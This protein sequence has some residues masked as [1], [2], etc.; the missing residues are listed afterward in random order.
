MAFYPPTAISTIAIAKE[1]ALSFKPILLID[2]A[3]SDGSTPAHFATDTLTYSSVSYTGCVTKSTLDRV[4][5]MNSTGLDNFP[6]AR[7][8]LADPSATLFRLYELNSTG[9]GFKGAI[10]TMTLVMMDKITGNFTSD[11]KIKFIGR[12]E[13]AQSTD[14]GISFL[15]KSKLDLARVNIPNVP[16]S[17]LCPY[18]F[19]G[20]AAEQATVN[21]VTSPFYYCGFPGGGGFTDCNYDVI[22]C[23]DRGMLS[24]G[25][26]GGV[27]YEPPSTWYN[28]HVY[29][30]G[31]KGQGWNTDNQAKYQSYVPMVYGAGFVKGVVANVLGNGDSV[32]FEVICAAGDHSAS[33]ISMVLV[34][35]VAVPHNDQDPLSPGNGN[36]PDD[37]FFWQYINT[38]IRNSS[39]NPIVPWN[40]QGDPY[41]SMLVIAVVV[42]S[43]VHGSSNS[44]PDVLVVCGAK[45]VRTY[46]AGLSPVDGPDAGRPIWTIMDIMCKSG[47]FSYSDFDLQSAV[48]A[49]AVCDV[50]VPFIGLDGAY[51]TVSVNNGSTA[52]TSA[53]GGLF[54][55]VHIYA[56]QTIQMGGVN[57][58]VASITDTSHL[59]LASPYT[60]STS[61][62]A[63]LLRSHGRYRL[64]LVIT[65]RTS[66]AELL[67]S[68]RLGC[69][70]NIAV[71]NSTNKLQFY[72]DQALGDQQPS[73]IAGSN[74]N[75]SYAS[76]LATG[77]NGEADGRVG[78]GHVAYNF[79]DSNILLDGQEPNYSS[80]LKISQ[81][82]S[83]H[84]PN[85][86]IVPFQN[87]E[88]SFVSDTSTRVDAEDYNRMQQPVEG[89]VR[90]EGIPNYDQIFRRS[91]N[92]MAR[93]FRGNPR[94]SPTYGDTGGTIQCELK[95]FGPRVAHLRVGNIVS[96]TS[97][98][99]GL[100]KQL[101]RV[102]SIATDDNFG[103][104]TVTM[105]WHDDRWYLDGYANGP[106]PQF[107][108]PASSITMRPPH[109]WIPY[110][111]VQPSATDPVFTSQRNWFLD[112]SLFYTTLSDS[113]VSAQL[114]VDAQ[115][116]VNQTSY[117]T[118]A[119]FVTSQGTVDVSTGSV[120]AANYYIGILSID[121]DGRIT[122]LQPP[123]QMC[124][125]SLA[126]T[127]S[128]IVPKIV[129]PSTANSGVWFWGNH[130]GRMYWGGT[131][132]KVSGAIPGFLKITSL[133]GGANPANN[134]FPAPDNKFDHIEISVKQV[135]H[136][137]PVGAA[138]QSLTTTTIQIDTGGAAFSSNQWVGYRCTVAGAPPNSTNSTGGIPIYNATITASTTGGL[139]TVSA[140][141]TAAGIVVGD[142]LIIYFKPVITTDAAGNT[143]VTDTNIANAMGTPGVRLD[144]TDVDGDNAFHNTFISTYPNPH[145]FT[146]GQTVS[147]SG[148]SGVSGINSTYPVAL[149]L[150]DWTVEISH[151]NVS[152]YSSDPYLGGG[153]IWLT[154]GFQVNELAGDMMRIINPDGT[155][156]SISILS[157]TATSFTSNGKMQV[158]PTS[159]SIIYIEETAWHTI[160]TTDRFSI[161]DPGSVS[162]LNSQITN[163]LGETVLI[164]TTLIDSSGNRSHLNFNPTRLLYVPGSGSANQAQI[165]DYTLITPDGSGNFTI[166]LAKG[167][168]FRG[169]LTGPSPSPALNVLFPIRSDGQSITAGDTFELSFDQNGTDNS[170][171]PTFNNN[172]GGTAGGFSADFNSPSFAVAP[173]A[174]TRTTWQCRFHGSTWTI[175]GF[176]TGLSTT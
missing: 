41:G 48:D 69:N 65:Q 74:D 119:P 31:Q 20:T 83:D 131:M 105:S 23:S 128:L 136:A 173:T 81:E 5:S 122:M 170:P 100:T 124:Q 102:T 127:G 126:A 151:T 94:S 76:Y 169:V 167:G 166:D 125:I 37:V 171:T 8:E 57:G 85:R 38:G 66:M 114:Y 91:N 71:N 153:Q 77:P 98:L 133:D 15:V 157:N 30:T 28:P 67:N 115:L 21:D 161:T 149:V 49:Q 130:P 116:P 46:D 16:I 160:N 63:P 146:A 75:T 168:V 155:C 158:P 143:V 84:T 58:R 141:P 10:V 43:S 120:T 50:N 36:R 162:S 13:P 89:S 108:S 6:S 39:P 24:L 163:W 96:L 26:F 12:A 123:D 64:N 111:G 51:G 61:A 165:T 54:D 55:G 159:S 174:N 52:V 101:F 40:S 140:D 14:R 135:L 109:A 176:Q 11:S 150:D 44:V 29:T 93:L 90:M 72:V 73:T 62:S 87:E 42:P 92:Y 148:V 88:N 107:A 156:Q 9:P 95:V 172:S 33:S 59:V 137:G 2:V 47:P 132:P 7:V 106:S 99:Y 22:S 25:R 103:I 56:N 34:N 104:A 129:W 3:F 80:T 164:M 78:T 27:Q 17:R 145:G 32:R 53:S 139:L 68:V 35:G 110:G 4:Q 112:V 147:V 152:W 134:P 144:I 121:A 79:N 175:A 18:P 45:T 70:L 19:P 142:A 1:Q 113:S 86:I 82:G 118:N 60:G 138:I 117:K 97:T 154:A